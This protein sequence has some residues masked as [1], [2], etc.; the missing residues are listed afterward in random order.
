MP[1]RCTLPG[2]ESDR[3]FHSARDLAFAL[4][5]VTVPSTGSHPGGKSPVLVDGNGENGC[6]PAGV[7]FGRVGGLSHDGKTLY[8]PAAPS[9]KAS[10]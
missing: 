3:H 2:K 4:R 10:M 8:A 9:S 5:T 7:Q 6:G 1:D